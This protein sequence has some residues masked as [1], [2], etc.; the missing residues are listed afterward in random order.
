MFNDD[1]EANKL[2]SDD[3]SKNCR[4][5]I[6]K[7]TSIIAPKKISKNKNKTSYL[8]KKCGAKLWAK[9][10]LFVMCGSCN[11]DIL[12]LITVNEIFFFSELSL[13][14]VDNMKERI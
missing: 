3:S 5:L 8:C 10:E 4:T 14:E 7:Q 9:A 1:L 12:E 11:Q 2:K 13:K 6:Q